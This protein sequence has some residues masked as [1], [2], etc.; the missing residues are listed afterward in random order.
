ML[1]DAGGDQWNFLFNSLAGMHYLHVCLSTAR[2]NIN[3]TGTPGQV[4]GLRCSQDSTRKN[5]TSWMLQHEY[6]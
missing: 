2:G 4:Y 3:C 5:G 1:T 6:P